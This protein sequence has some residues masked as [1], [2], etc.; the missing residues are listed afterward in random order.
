MIF[1]PGWYLDVLAGMVCFSQHCQICK[2]MGNMMEAK[3]VVVGNKPIRQ[4]FHNNEW[5]FSVWDVVEALTDTFDAADYI[6][7]MLKRDNHLA[8]EWER[9][10]IPLWL[11]T[12]GGSQKVDCVNIEG[13]L[14]ITQ[15][16]PSYKA[17]PLKR[18]LA[19]VG[20]ERIREIDN[21]NLVSQRTRAHYK[22]KG[23][24]DAWIEKRMFSIKVSAELMEEWKKRGVQEELDSTTL[25]TEISKATFGM[26]PREY[27][28][29][30]G[31]DREN[32]RD[33][34]TSLELVFS[35]LGEA[36]TT[37]IAEKGHEGFYS[38]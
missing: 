14:R 7:E 22:A 3:P 35:M 36:A 38:E 17:E 15:S 34:M 18:W 24:S 31:L 9:I 28:Q 10:A 13:L 20:Y 1:F 33:H 37:E 30:K 25:T 21:P 12:E 16:I 11:T 5:W 6:K 23:Y 8:N 19:R 4:T 29:F 26:T 32:L 27:K 2:N